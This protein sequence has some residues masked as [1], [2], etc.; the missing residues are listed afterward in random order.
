MGI[1]SHT[2]L[3]LTLVYCQVDGSHIFSYLMQSFKIL[4]YRSH[5]I[6]IVVCTA[7]GDGERIMQFCPSYQ[8][9]QHMKAGDSPQAACDKVVTDMLTQTNKWFEVGLIALDNKVCMYVC[10]FTSQ[11]I[12]ED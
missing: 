12:S 3:Y 5:T 2:Y 8:I 10:I 11:I 9:V 7:T 1:D 4:V 6:K